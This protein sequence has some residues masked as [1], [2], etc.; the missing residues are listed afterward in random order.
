MKIKNI[1]KSKRSQG[2]FGLS[3]GTIWG[4]ILIV[5]FIVGAFFGIRAFLDYQKCTSIGMFFNGLQSDVNRAWNSQDSNFRYNSSLP[6]GS[7]YVCFLNVTG[8][9][10]NANAI[11]TT[12]Y[13]TIKN[14]GWAL[15]NNAYLYAPSKDFCTKWTSIKHLNL[16]DHNPICA[17]VVKN[18]VSIKVEKKFEE[19][20]VRLSE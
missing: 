18:M 3:F 5:F 16:T 20:L 9:V 14:A 13:D 12:L 4:I 10:K 19:N 17:K 11:E 15:G 8:S 1:L 2:V 7:E 6:A